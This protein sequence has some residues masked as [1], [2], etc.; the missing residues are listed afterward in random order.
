MPLIAS[1]DRG[2]LAISPEALRTKLGSVQD[3]SMS[4]TQ[5]EETGPVDDMPSDAEM[6]S[7]QSQLVDRL[8]VLFHGIQTTLFAQEMAAQQ[9][10]QSIVDVWAATNRYRAAGNGQGLGP[11]PGMPDGQVLPDGEPT[12]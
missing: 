4:R 8:E 9:Q 1:V 7:A 6:R 12:Q 11:I 3:G 5:G 10:L 2:S